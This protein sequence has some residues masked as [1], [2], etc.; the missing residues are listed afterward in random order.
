MKAEYSSDSAS[1]KIEYSSDSASDPGS[2]SDEHSISVAGVRASAKP[3]AMTSSTVRSN[4]R[5]PRGNSRE[6]REFQGIPGSP[7]KARRTMER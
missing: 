1:E 3:S 5:G 7:G 4:S 2:E 6:P